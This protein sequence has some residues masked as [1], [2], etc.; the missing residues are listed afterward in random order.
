MLLVTEVCVTVT[1]V[2]FIFHFAACEFKCFVRY[3]PIVQI[4]ESSRHCLFGRGV[5]LTDHSV[6]GRRHCLFGRGVSLTDHSVV[7]NVTVFSGMGS[8]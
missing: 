5:S 4:S 3:E 2:S 7:V 8:A 1:C 6:N